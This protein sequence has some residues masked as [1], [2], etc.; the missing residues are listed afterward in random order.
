MERPPQHF[1]Q[2]I[3]FNKAI[4]CQKA[5]DLRSSVSFWTS[6]SER[7]K[8][9]FDNPLTSNSSLGFE[10]FFSVIAGKKVVLF[11]L[12]NSIG[13]LSSVIRMLF[14]IPVNDSRNEAGI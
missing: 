12:M 2:L 1:R 14:K 5:F 4:L 13:S 9:V 7:L 10:Q 11:F 3:S 8:H 6:L